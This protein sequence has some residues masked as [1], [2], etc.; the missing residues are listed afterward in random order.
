MNNILLDNDL[1]RCELDKTIPVLKHQWLKKPSS[2]AFRSQ[3]MDIQKIYLEQK[4]EHANLKWLA[5]TALLGELTSEDERWM[6]ETW[7]RLLFVEAEL[8]VHAVILGDDIFADYSMEHFKLEADKTFKEKGVKLGIFL[9]E[10][11]AYAWLKDN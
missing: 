6:E 3:L 9:D 4:K 7:E 11:K 8:K 1:V 10:E 2:E 5:D